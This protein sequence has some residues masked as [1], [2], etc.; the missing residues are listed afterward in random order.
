MAKVWHNLRSHDAN[1]KN[2]FI[3]FSRLLETLWQQI[4]ILFLFSFLP[5]AISPDVQK[6]RMFLFWHNLT[7]AYGTKLACRAV[8]VVINP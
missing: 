2:F 7:Y 1:G 5:A 8:H 4:H 6:L 3:F